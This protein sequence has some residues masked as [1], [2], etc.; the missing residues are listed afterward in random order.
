M[1]HYANPKGPTG[2]WQTTPSTPSH[3][4]REPPSAA[5]TYPIEPPLRGHAAPDENQLTLVSP[6]G[7]LSA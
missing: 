7:L 3:S 6:L 4:N 5:F 1:L 2:Q